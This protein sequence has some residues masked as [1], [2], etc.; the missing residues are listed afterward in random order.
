M[1]I[2]SNK[3]KDILTRLYGMYYT[4]SVYNISYR[5]LKSYNEKNGVEYYEF[6]F[7][8][9][10]RNITLY[11]NSGHGSLL[12]KKPIITVRKGK[13]YSRV[14]E[15]QN[16]SIEHLTIKINNSNYDK[17]FELI[18]FILDE[19]LKLK[20]DNYYVIDRLHELKTCEIQFNIND[21]DI[22][23]Q[24][25]II[26]I[27]SRYVSCLFTNFVIL[28]EDLVCVNL[29]DLTHS[30]NKPVYVRGHLGANKDLYNSVTIVSDGVDKCYYVKNVIRKHPDGYKCRREIIDIYPVHKILTKFDKALIKHA[31][32][33]FYGTITQ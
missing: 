2:Y 21:D 8:K 7:S 25:G 23:E 26:Q 16:N 17:A 32:N 33:K 12:Y 18:N 30:D 11:V 6:K 14:H 1:P 15:L 3:N 31:L 28:N 10:G 27:N 4:N 13:G 9:Q 5:Y 22:I 20:S 29:D 24:N 19:T